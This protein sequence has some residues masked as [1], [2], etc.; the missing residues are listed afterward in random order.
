MLTTAILFGLVIGSFLNV[1]IYRVPNNES[2]MGRSHCPGCANQIAAYDNVPV[3]SWVALRGKCRKCHSRISPQYP[4]VEGVTGV[5]FGVVVWQFGFSLTTVVLLFF[6]AVSVALFVID[7]QTLRLPDKIVIP[8][9]IVVT[10][11]LLATSLADGDVQRFLLA[12]VSSIALASFYFIIW[13][14]TS[15]RGLG[16]G[17]VKLA[18]TLGIVMGYFS[19]EAVITGTAA[20]WLIG[21]VVGVFAIAIGRAS[22]GKPIPFGPFLLL[23]CWI[24]VFV[25][26]SIFTGYWSFMQSLG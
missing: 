13:V 8:S 18:P 20:A 10:M 15:G 14:A 26:E 19:W 21:A 11:G 4:I 12:L 2:L 24:G 16:F 5:F 23:G 17:D 6:A 1:V 22:R 3:L 7:L 9:F 25:G